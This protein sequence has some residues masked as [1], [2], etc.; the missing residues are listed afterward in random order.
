MNYLACFLTFFVKV[1][2]KKN[3]PSIIE[4]L[5]LNEYNFILFLNLNVKFRPAV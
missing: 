3:S 2:T 1:K 4:E 5:F